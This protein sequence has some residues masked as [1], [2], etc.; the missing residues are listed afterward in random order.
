MKTLVDDTVAKSTYTPYYWGEL[1][2][3]D[4]CTSRLLNHAAFGSCRPKG[5]GS[6]VDCVGDG[7]TELTQTPVGNV[8]V[9]VVTISKRYFL[10]S[11]GGQWSIQ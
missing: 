6:Y 1:P 8:E 11:I 2:F 7:R 9:R 5:M 4:R 3:L 10:K